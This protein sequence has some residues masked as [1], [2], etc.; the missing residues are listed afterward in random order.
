MRRQCE[1]SSYVSFGQT[2]RS[3][4]SHAPSSVWCAPSQADLTT[5]WAA[6]ATSA[7]RPARPVPKHAMPLRPSLWALAS[8]WLYSVATM[9]GS[10]SQVSSPQM[11]SHAARSPA[12]KSSAPFVS[13]GWR[14][15][16][17]MSFSTEM[18]S[19]GATGST[20]P[21]GRVTRSALATASAQPSA[22]RLDSWIT[23]SPARSTPPKGS[24]STCCP[25]SLLR[26]QARVG[27]PMVA[28][29]ASKSPGSWAA[30]AMPTS[31]VARRGERDSPR[32]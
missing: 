10:S 32:G 11:P 5:R 4:A 3:P 12:R 19:S 26:C 23:I 31:L 1:L 21:D 7:T 20:R 27:S 14:R 8:S 22:L 16:H 2:A 15:A 17:A 28:C 25:S 29:R 6:V 30:T 13:A 18:S 24:A 9:A